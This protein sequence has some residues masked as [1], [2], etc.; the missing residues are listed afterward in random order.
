MEERGSSHG[1]ERRGKDKGVVEEG[2]QLATSKR[3]RRRMEPQPRRGEGRRQRDG[4]RNISKLQMREKRREMEQKQR[5]KKALQQ[6]D[7]FN[8]YA[9]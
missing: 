8:I 1:Q 3:G 9:S 2:F 7:Y 6:N 5:G 4:D